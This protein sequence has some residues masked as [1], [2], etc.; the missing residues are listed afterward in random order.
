MNIDGGRKL[1][2]GALLALTASCTVAS[3]PATVVAIDIDVARQSPER[4]MQQYANPIERG[5]RALP[6]ISNIVSQADHGKVRV[7]AHFDDGATRQDLLEVNEMIEKL[8][9]DGALPER[10]YPAQLTA[11][12]IPL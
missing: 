9:R 2:A 4:L 12:R 1:L 7:E 10:A 11:P 5:L 6:R 8:K 3:T